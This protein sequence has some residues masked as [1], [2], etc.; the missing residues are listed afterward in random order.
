MI[1][2]TS[3]EDQQDIGGDQDTHG[4]VKPTMSPL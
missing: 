4:P 2:R 1:V 3:S